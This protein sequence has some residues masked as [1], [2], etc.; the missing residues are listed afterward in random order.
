M[1]QNLESH[2]I[3]C[4][5]NVQQ[6]ECLYCDQEFI[7]HLDNSRVFVIALTKK[8]I[9]RIRGHG[10]QGKKDVLAQEFDYILRRKGSKVM[11]PVIMDHSSKNPMRW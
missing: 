1:V 6:E 8:C 3:S 2:G 9:D 11:I 4:N 5:Y 10:K 7:D